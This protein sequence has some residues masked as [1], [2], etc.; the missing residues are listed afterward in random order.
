MASRGSFEHHA[1]QPLN[2]ET[3]S[4]SFL[5]FESSSSSAECDAIVAFVKERRP[6]I[7]LLRAFFGLFH[8]ADLWGQQSSGADAPSFQSSAAAAFR[9]PAFRAACVRRP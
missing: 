4:D 8:H 5:R 1:M 3:S 9:L 6:Q 2:V 7:S